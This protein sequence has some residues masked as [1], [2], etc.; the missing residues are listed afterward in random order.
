MRAD[1]LLS[2]MMLLQTRGKMTAQSLA[3]KLEVSRR[4]ILRDIDALSTAGVPVYAE[5]GHGGGIALDEN[6]RTT[7]TGLQDREIRALFVGSNTQLLSEIGLGEAAESTLLKLL[8]VLPASHQLAVEHIRQRIL[9]DPTWWWHDA[10]PLA[11]WD[12]LQQAVYKDRCIRAVYER[13]NGERVERILEPYS[14]VAKSSVWYLIAR[15][16]EKLRTYRVSRFQ[17]ITL[18]D[19]SFHRREEFDLPTYWREHLQDFVETQAGYCFTL[20]IHPD[21]LNFLKSIIPGRYHPVEPPDAAGWVIVHFQLESL[22]LAKMLV[23]GLG[24]QSII[25]EPLELREAVLS[26]AQELLNHY[27]GSTE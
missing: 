11:F 5:G 24:Q 10:Q 19:T 3:E 14:L 7:L 26:M 27:T 18:L 1:R 2:L 20:R 25:I 21:R 4:T 12:Q 15:Q 16:D 6:Y 17:Q 8:A 13:P 23:F 9:I 22:D